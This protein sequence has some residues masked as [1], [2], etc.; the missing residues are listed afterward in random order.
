MAPPCSGCRLALAAL[1]AQAAVGGDAAKD[2]PQ[3]GRDSGRRM[4]VRDGWLV[5][6]VQTSA[7]DGAMG[8]YAYFDETATPGFTFANTEA[9]APVK[10]YRDGE[11]VW[12]GQALLWRSTDGMVGSCGMEICTAMIRRKENHAAHQW[13]RGD[14]IVVKGFHDVVFTTTTGPIATEAGT[15]IALI[16]IIITVCIMVCA[17]SIL[18]G[19]YIKRRRQLRA[20]AEELGE[21]PA[22]KPIA[23]SSTQSLQG[24]DSLERAPPQGPGPAAQK[25]ADPAE[26]NLVML[27]GAR[28]EGSPPE[29]AAS[30]RASSGEAEAPPAAEE[31]SQEWSQELD[32]EFGDMETPVQPTYQDLPRATFTWQKYYQNNI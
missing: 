10:Q 24:R 23:S 31:L 4:F 11:L 16:L 27:A 25:L 28:R 9:D 7:F 1:L 13:S 32:N 12:E 20:K 6:N 21:H 19:L 30:A 26:V 17:C 15:S 22:M 18:F 8:R 5:H 29:S 2:P 3:L 14:V